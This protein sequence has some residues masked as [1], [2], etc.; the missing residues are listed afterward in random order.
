[1]NPILKAERRKKYE[2]PFGILDIKYMHHLFYV[3]M[4]VLGCIK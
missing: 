3:D 2:W 4:P 1:V